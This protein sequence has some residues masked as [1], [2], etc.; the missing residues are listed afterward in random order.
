M[1]LSP[2]STAFRARA[3]WE[4]CRAYTTNS[5]I[6]CPQPHLLSSRHSLDS[7]S[8]QR[9]NL[10]PP[11]EPPKESRPNHHALSIYED[12]GEMA[13]PFPKAGSLSSNPPQDSA[14]NRHLSLGTNTTSPRKDKG[15]GKAKETAD[16]G[17]LED[18]SGEP[19]SSCPN[20]LHQPAS[21]EATSS[22]RK[23]RVN[24]P[25]RRP[26]HSTKP[27]R[28]GESSTPQ[29]QEPNQNNDSQGRS[30]GMMAYPVR[31]FGADNYVSLFSSTCF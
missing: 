13:I 30:W 12:P 25:P 5:G 31:V 8:S 19:S 28:G 23:K 10:A 1:K 29:H 26:K 21:T 16:A 11:P 14:S 24:V 27:L 7:S 18:S 22:E 6:V 3:W 17:Q 4:K 2:S 20:I 9:S 15:K